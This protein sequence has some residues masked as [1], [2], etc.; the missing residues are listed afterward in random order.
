MSQSHGHTDYIIFTVY[1]NKSP[2]HDHLNYENVKRKLKSRGIEF[3]ELS[4]RQLYEISSS[5]FMINEKYTDLVLDLC[6]TYDQKFFISAKTYK[7]GLRKVF[8]NYLDGT[9]EFRG[10]FRSVDKKKAE[11][12]GRYFYRYDLD[13]YWIISDSDNTQIT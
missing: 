5:Y 2:I 7:H 13:K 10:Y 9:V 6:E 8:F 4:V 1:Q 11:E 3:V 12:E